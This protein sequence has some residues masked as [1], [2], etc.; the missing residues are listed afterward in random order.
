MP[1]VCNPMRYAAL[2]G[3]SAVAIARLEP[4]PPSGCRRF[5]HW[6]A[7]LLRCHWSF[8]KSH[9]PKAS[10]VQYKQ[11]EPQSLLVNPARPELQIR[12]RSTLSDRMYLG[13]PW[14]TMASASYSIT[15]LDSIHSAQ[16]ITKQTRVYPVLTILMIFLVPP[17]QR[18]TLQYSRNLLKGKI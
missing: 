5:L 15:S 9:S 7:H 4:W 8:H 18:P 16:W 1:A 11:S 6:E 12:G 10:L 17:L 2:L 3:C 14:I 13:M